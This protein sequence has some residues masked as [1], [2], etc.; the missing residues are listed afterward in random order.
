MNQLIV[1]KAAAFSM[2]LGGF[3]AFIS[4]VI[5]FLGGLVSSSS[6]ASQF[7]GFILFTISFLPAVIILYYM[8]KNEKHISYLTNQEGAI[9]GAVIGFCVTIGFFLIFAP[10]ISILHLLMHVSSYGITDMFS[11][12]AWLF[13]IIVFMLALITAA[14][15]SVIGMGF[16]YATNKLAK[17]PENLDARLDIKIED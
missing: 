10:M 1:K 15:N 9:L 13:F 14:T 4:I 12:G 3:L 8:K 5:H 11:M 6:L 2:L 7:L 17:D 16:I